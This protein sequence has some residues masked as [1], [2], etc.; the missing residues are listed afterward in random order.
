MRV[1]VK[2]IQKVFD[3]GNRETVVLKDISIDI[4]SG[5]SLAVL[6]VSGSGKST[7]LN[8]L[9]ILMRP[10]AGRVLFDDIDIF[11]QSETTI[12]L[13]RNQSIGFVFQSFNLLPEFSCL[14]NVMLPALVGGKTWQQAEM[15]ARKL[16]E[17][18]GLSD[19][20]VHRPGEISGGEAQ[21]VAIA[22]ALI[23]EPRLIIAD[24]PT[25]NLDSENGEKVARL[26]SLLSLQKGITV[27]VATHNASLAEM[28]ARQITIT[29]GRIVHEE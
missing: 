14:E 8:I 16:L 17:E 25:G 3:K 13:F 6:G 18:M 23:M 7:L 27:I 11:A 22:R 5:T 19:R 10:S 21:R 12:S 9:G 2:K 26:L 24:E 1:D 4:A 28:M 29:D 20:G 15:S